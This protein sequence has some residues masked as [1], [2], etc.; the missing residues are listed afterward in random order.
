MNGSG[1][2]EL[3]PT[4]I[5]ADGRDEFMSRTSIGGSKAV[6]FKPYRQMYSD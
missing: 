6:A 5:V 3:S 1:F 4:A 2:H